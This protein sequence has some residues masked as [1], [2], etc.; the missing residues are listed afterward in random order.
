MPFMFRCLPFFI[1]ILIGTQLCAQNTSVSSYDVLE[2]QTDSLWFSKSFIV[3][4]PVLK[5][6]L[7]V[8][9]R[10]GNYEN[11][12]ETLMQL[13]EYMAY[14]ERDNEKAIEH[15]IN[16]MDLADRHSLNELSLNVRSKMLYF[17][18]VTTQDYDLSAEILEEMK[19]INK[20][21]KSEF[22][23]FVN[24]QWFTQFT[25]TKRY[26]K[27]HVAESDILKSVGIVKETLK[28][29]NNQ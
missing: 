10:E 17:H 12:V 29:F 26:K 7:K 11:T 5:E 22:Y 15:L 23:D 6:M 27:M 19:M 28:Y 16:A 1:C 13:H 2:Q 8:S 21:L 4:H 20:E 18:Q 25:R 3:L 14:I 24:K 9:E